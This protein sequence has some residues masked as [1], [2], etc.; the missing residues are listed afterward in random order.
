MP[1]ISKLAKGMSKVCDV[2]ESDLPGVLGAMMAEDAEEADVV[3]DLRIFADWSTFDQHIELITPLFGGWF[4]H[5]DFDRIFTGVIFSNNGAKHT[6][7]GS[8]GFKRLNF[9]T[10]VGAVVS[11]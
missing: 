11:R 1:Q 3:N 8:E 10:E 4:G 7:K 9:G 2:W 5:Y 6:S